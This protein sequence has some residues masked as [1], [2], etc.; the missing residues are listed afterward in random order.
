MFYVIQRNLL[1]EA[2]FARL[3]EAVTRYDLDHCFVDII[4]FTSSLQE[5]IEP[6][7]PCMIFGS[8]TL[9]RIATER[10]WTPGSFLNENHDARIWIPAYGPHALNSDAIFCT[11]G[12]VPDRWDPFFIRPCLDSKSFTGEVLDRKEFAEWRDKVLKSGATIDEDTPVMIAEPTQINAEYRF[13]IVDGKVITGSIYKL[14][15]RAMTLPWNRN[16]TVPIDT[17]ITEFV[18]ERAAQ[19]SPARGY[20]LDVARTPMGP[21][22]IEIN[23]LNSAGF[24]KCDISLILQAIEAM[25]W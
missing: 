4:P 9:A 23:N 18:R 12:N 7:Q 22:V 8:T 14:D 13:F 3:V 11:F 19:W 5:E 16:T 6:K 20:V 24:Y 10:A 2:D 25:E 17:E 21:K 1:N 15:G